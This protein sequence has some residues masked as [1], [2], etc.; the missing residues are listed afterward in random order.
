VN[1]VDECAVART[2]LDYIHLRHNPGDTVRVGI[3]RGDEKRE[4][5]VRLHENVLPESVRRAWWRLSD[6]FR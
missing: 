3:L 5:S 4:E 2:A 1:D 6:V